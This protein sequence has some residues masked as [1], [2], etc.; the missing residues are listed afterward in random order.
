VFRLVF[1]INS[2][3][4]TGYTVNAVG[5]NADTLKVLAM[6]SQTDINARMMAKPE[7]TGKV[8]YACFRGLR[9]I[10]R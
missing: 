5:R 6:L 1:S 10:A 8:D 4:R 3:E 7:A 2:F 9:H